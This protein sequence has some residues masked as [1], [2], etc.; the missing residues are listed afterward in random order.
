[1]E[2]F[3]EDLE[4][5]L[6]KYNDDVTVLDDYEIEEAFIMEVMS[7]YYSK[8]KTKVLSIR[9]SHVFDGPNVSSIS[10]SLSIRFDVK[11]LPDYNIEEIKKVNIFVKIPIFETPNE[12]SKML[13][14]KEVRVYDEFFKDLKEFHDHPIKGPFTPPT[15]TVI[16]QNTSS[17]SNPSILVLSN[18]SEEGFYSPRERFLDKNELRSVIKTL[19]KFHADGIKY[20]RD[21]KNKEYDFLQVCAKINFSVFTSFTF[22]SEMISAK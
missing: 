1:M 7:S 9:N 11:I 8:Q 5:I 17:S 20:L 21:N 12:A 18:V 14:S 10:I 2:K 19:A 3:L 22:Y 15:P 4:K 6:Q 13:C 16:F